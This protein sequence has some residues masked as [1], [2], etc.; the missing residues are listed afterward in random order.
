VKNFDKL[1]AMAETNPFL[2]AKLHTTFAATMAQGSGQSNVL[3]MHAS[4]IVN[5]RTLQGD[6]VE[7]TE[8]YI[9]AL[10]P[11]GVQVRHINGNDPTPNIEPK[12]RVFELIGSIERERLGCEVVLVPELLPGGT[13]ARNYAGIC[14]DVYRYTGTISNGKGGPAHG[15]NE[16]YDVANAQSSI[17]F[18]TA[19]L[20]RY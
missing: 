15:I 9:R 14:D 10:L 5:S 17:D 2:D 16:Y 13:D 7:S 20:K 8:E 12:G 11:E 6:T 18:Y 3:P 1:C 19:F 4:V